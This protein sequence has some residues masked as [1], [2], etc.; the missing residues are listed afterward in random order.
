MLETFG[1]LESFE[2][3]STVA[4][5]ECDLP[6]VAQLTFG[7]DGRTL[8][9]EEPRAAAA[10]L[11]ALKVTAIG[12]NCTVGPA[13]LHDVVAELAAGCAL[14]IS[15]Q[16]NAGVPRRL[17]RQLRYARNTEYFAEAAGQFVASGATLV[18]GCCG[19]TPAHIRAVAR[20]VRP[21]R[22][23]G[24]KPALRLAG[25]AW[26]FA[27]CPS[28]Q[29][30]SQPTGH[31]RAASSWWPECEPRKDRTWPSSPLT[32]PS[33][34]GPAPACWQSPTTRHPQPASALSPPLPYWGERA[35]TGVILTMETA[36]RSLAALEA[37][38][39]GGY[40]LGVQTVVCRSG[41]PWVA[42]DYPEPQSPGDINSV[43]LITAL[44]A[45]NAGVDWRGVPVPGRTRFVIGASV[46]TA[47]ADTSQELSR[48][49]E[50]ARAGAHFL[51]TDVI[52][53]VSP[54]LRLLRELRG[55]GVGLPVIAAFAPFG[56][57]RRSPGLS[58]RSPGLRCRRWRTAREPATTR[59]LPTLCPPCLTG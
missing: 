51:V 41:T 6:V 2:Q 1:D 44:A 17:G 11:A 59:T 57:P 39:L 9:G 50:K 18:G 15:V 32:R 26:P 37:D 52:Y 38:L 13:V 21:L 33:L 19:T 34:S 54:A 23:A 36:G 27:S 48:A 5:A 12:A 49:G 28:S 29:T 42:G 10:A 35:G 8:R 47:A 7:D 46:H 43:R 58:T 24:R 55:R 40:A 3:A 20:S 25:H 31:T 22:P 56:D 30:P 4:L 53:D 45:L 14:P 16:P